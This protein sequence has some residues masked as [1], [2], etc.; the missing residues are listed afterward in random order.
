M[1]NGGGGGSSSSSEKYYLNE[2]FERKQISSQTLLSSYFLILICHPVLPLSEE[3]KYWCWFCFSSLL[4]INSNIQFFLICRSNSPASE[5][6]A[7]QQVPC[8]I[9]RFFRVTKERGVTFQQLN[10]LKQM[11]SQ[12][13]IVSSRYWANLDFIFVEQ[14]CCIFQILVIPNGRWR[15]FFQCILKLSSLREELNYLH[16]F[17]RCLFSL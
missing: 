10:F 4:Y 15:I 12:W 13:N 1:T 16:R 14:V 7:M 6:K 2:L 3:T 8:K 11:V 17:N 5:T 9:T